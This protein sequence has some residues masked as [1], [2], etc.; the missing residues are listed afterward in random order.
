MFSSRSISPSLIWAAKTFLF[1]F[2]SGL[3]G[4]SPDTMLP[5]GK[6]Y[7]STIWLSATGASGPCLGFTVA[8]AYASVSLGNSHPC[9]IMNFSRTLIRLVFEALIA[10][11][12]SKSAMHSWI[13]SSLLIFALFLIILARAPNFRVEIVSSKLY[14]AGDA[15]MISEVLEFPPRDS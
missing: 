9:S 4:T 6:F 3:L 14:L 15:V 10:F 7:S 12:F 13:D 1:S 5:S 8:F 11:S 2:S